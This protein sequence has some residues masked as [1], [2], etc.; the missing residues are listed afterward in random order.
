MV[1]TVTDQTGVRRYSGFC[2]FRRP[3]DVD[4]H[5]EI[6]IAFCDGEPELWILA[7]DAGY[8][9]LKRYYTDGMWYSVVY[10]RASVTLVNG[11]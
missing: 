8:D 11:R 2:S 1:H 5:G 9:E 4:V 6:V 7:D 10:T 3:A